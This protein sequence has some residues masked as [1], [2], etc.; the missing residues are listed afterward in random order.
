MRT[1]SK[2]PSKALSS[3]LREYPDSATK[4]PAKPR[5]RARRP[6]RGGGGEVYP[7]GGQVPVVDAE[8]LGPRLQGKL[9]L[10]LGVHLHQASRPK[11]RAL[12]R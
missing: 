10:P 1:A 2:S 5:F 9:Q 6:R 3:S 11:A 7:Q 12:S 4:T 8:D